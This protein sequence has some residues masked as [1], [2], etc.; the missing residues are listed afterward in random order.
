MSC[1]SPKVQDLIGE[2]FHVRWYKTINVCSIIW[3]VCPIGRMD[4]VNAQFKQQSKHNLLNSQNCI[5]SF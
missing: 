5:V 4:N 1:K 2:L 3:Y